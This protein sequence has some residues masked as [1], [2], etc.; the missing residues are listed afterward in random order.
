MKHTKLLFLMA[1]LLV[2]T[3][4]AG[5][6][7]SQT[8]KVLTEEEIKTQITIFSGKETVK[9]RAGQEYIN[10]LN[11][12][13]DTL[14]PQL[15]AED[16]PSRRPARVTM[17]AMGAHAGRRDSMNIEERELFCATLA[18]RLNPATPQP[19]QVTIVRELERI[20]RAE[21]VPAISELLYSEDAELKDVARRALQ[22]NNSPQAAEALRIGLLVASIQDAESKWT[23]GLI[24]ALANRRDVASV[25]SLSSMLQYQD[26]SIA[27]ACAQGLGEIATPDGIEAVLA[28]RKNAEGEVRDMMADA[29]ICGAIKLAKEGNKEVALA[30]CKKLSGTDEPMQ[31][32]IVVMYTLA[33]LQPE[34]ASALIAAGLNDESTRMK[35]AAIQL[36]WEHPGT[37][38]AK[39]LADK[40]ASLSLPNQLQAIASLTQNGDDAAQDALIKATAS[41]DESVR[42]AAIGALAKLGNATTANALLDIAS[43]SNGNTAN[44][45]KKSLALL[46]GQKAE[47]AILDAAA[48]GPAARRAIAISTFVPR[49]MKR[50]TPI[51]AGYACEA[52]ATVA[53]PALDALASFGTSR[54]T[55]VV[56]GIAASAKDSG[57]R[58][59]ANNALKAICKRA[60]DKDAVAKTVLAQMNQTD[61]KGQAELIAVLPTVGGK[62]A[63]EAINEA[64]DSDN[65]DINDAAVR[66]AAAWP[67]AD[68]LD[69]LYV[70][71][72]DA[73]RDT[74]QHVLA[75]R[76]ILRL[77]ESAK[78]DNENRVANCVAVIEIA[79][80][81]EEKKA[82]LATL[83]KIIDPAAAKAVTPLLAVDEL[84]ND[85]AQ[86][87]KKIAEGLAKSKR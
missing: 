19:A 49:S 54:Q 65:A 41:D 53:R 30:I 35:E 78:K 66:A 24:N 70:I 29:A 52:D 56:A 43:K 22:K 44:A 83:G 10:N 39:V 62:A 81:I 67:N 38:T 40:L 61:A 63:I 17:A 72:G 25:S 1:G 82:A 46:S 36:S 28:A 45:A 3:L 14:I 71:A 68:A 87:A 73:Q 79:R 31:T 64:I 16:I 18:A 69:V 85:A 23:I 75:I 74:T 80:R 8:V 42:V 9:K 7:P 4:A 2:L 11:Q 21:C 55:G 33:N 59:S 37:T 13:L 47:A 5:C 27:I 84:H 58:K 77:V 32:R 15:S 26:K 86:A 57:V 60:E 51:L 34:K 50:S 12:V 76:G 48:S 6:A 20:G